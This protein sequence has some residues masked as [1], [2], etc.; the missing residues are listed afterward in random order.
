MPEIMIIPARNSDS[1]IIRTAAYARVSTDSKDQ[2]NS[3]SAQIEHYTEKLKGNAGSVLIDIYADEGIT[4]TTAVKRDEFNRMMNDCRRGKIDRILTKSVSRFARNTIDCLEAVRELKELG[5]SVYFEKENIDTAEISSE[6]MITVYSRFAEEE[7]ISI[8]KNVR[9]GI[10]KRMADG[11]FVPSAVPYGYVKSETGFEIDT[12]TADTVREIFTGYLC[13]ESIETLSKKHRLSRGMVA[14]IL[15]NEKYTGNSVFQ[16]WYTTD[17]LPYRC[18]ENKGEKAKY[19]VSNTH[20]EIISE[21]VYE[22]VRELIEDKGKYRRGKPISENVFRKKIY[23][24]IC[25][26]LYKLKKRNESNYWVCRNHDFKA[27]NCPAKQIPEVEIKKA[28][29]VMLNKLITAHNEIFPPM[30][31]QL[32]AVYDRKTMENLRAAEIRKEIAELKNKMHITARLYAEGVLDSGYYNARINEMEHSAEVLNK[33]LNSIVGDDKENDR[34]RMIRQIS[35]VI[36][37]LKISQDF[38]EK[39]F[40]QIAEKIV[41][42][43]NG[44][45]EFHLNGGLKFSQP[46]NRNGVK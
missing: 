26:T 21:S 36:S 28:F 2:L 7:S 4:G 9:F 41:V 44:L 11:T 13:G 42:Y 6:L 24:G 25:G 1:E 40:A 15:T 29:T 32:I 34:I 22:K 19:Y 17:T 39:V 38:N 45:L 3:L 37:A 46:I 16:K 14:Y 5:V 23:C 10:Q 18:K 27:E 12:A 30:I 33:R 20:E 43:E 8:S 31:K 35:G